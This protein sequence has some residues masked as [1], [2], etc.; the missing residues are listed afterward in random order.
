[1]KPVY[2]CPNCDH[3]STRQ[4]NLKTH[5]KRRHGGAGRPIPKVPNAPSHSPA[6]NLSGEF[7]PRYPN[8][9][10]PNSKGDQL[11]QVQRNIIEFSR[12]VSPYLYGGLRSSLT[13]FLAASSPMNLGFSD[14]RNILGYKGHVCRKCLS[15][16]IE[17]IHDDEERVLSKSNYICDPRK[18]HETQFVTDTTGTIYKQRQELISHLTLCCTNDIFNQQELLNLA[19]VEI[20]PRADSYEESIDLDTLSSGIP[21]WAYRAIKEGKTIIN[22]TDLAEFL[23]IFESTLGFLRLTI[24]G[25]E[26]YFF[27]YIAKGLEPRDIKYL[28]KFLDADTPITTGVS[29][30]MNNG[31]IDREWKET[32]IDRPLA[33]I[34]PSRPD[35]FNFLPIMPELSEN[36]LDDIRER[37]ENAGL[38]GMRLPISTDSGFTMKDCVIHK[39]WQWFVYTDE[40]LTSKLTPMISIV[41]PT[42]P[43]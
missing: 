43:A 30:A 27:V 24:D 39:D 10:F 4:W 11:D 37:Q 8:N 41:L 42:P 12:I 19:A 9:L 2:S 18:L 35:K 34:P 25:V 36:E 40:S 17:V 33:S 23:N 28:K 16:H 13:P 15:W 1:M 38:F 26:H 6:N 21:A 5:I 29:I 31:V 32:F 7:K 22:R 3:E 14:G 20:P